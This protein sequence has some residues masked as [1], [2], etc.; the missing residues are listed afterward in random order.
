MTT[1]LI[2]AY[3]QLRQRRADEDALHNAVVEVIPHQSEVRNM[4]AY[5]KRVAW[6]KRPRRPTIEQGKILYQVSPPPPES[7]L[8][9][10]EAQLAVRNA[11]TALPLRERLV[12]RQHD[13]G[14]R[15]FN[16]VAKRVG[17]TPAAV[18]SL[19][20]RAH[21]RLARSLS[22]MAPTD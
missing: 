16:H 22:H 4:G 19:Q 7:D 10:R 11:V 14:G 8:E 21:R 3:E 18:R 15:S 20:H 5:L 12:V 13:L 2:I 1:P 17:I 9:R 6:T